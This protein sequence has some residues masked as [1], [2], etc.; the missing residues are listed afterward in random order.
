MKPRAWNI[1]THSSVTSCARNGT[2]LSSP[3]ISDSERGSERG[4]PFGVP[5]VPLVRIVIRGHSSGL[6]G[7]PALGALDQRI[8]RVVAGL[9]RPGAEPPAGR[10]VDPAQ[11]VCVLVVVDE[12]IGPLALGYLP[13]L[14]PR[15]RSVEQHDSCAALRGCE[16][17]LEEAP[18]VA[19]QNR[20]ALAGLQA[21][22]APRVGQRVGALVELLIAELAALV[23]H[24]RPVAVANRPGHDRTREQA[25]ALEAGYQLRDATWRLGSHQPTADA[26][27]GEICLVAGAL[28]KLG[29]ACNQ[30]L[31]VASGA[32]DGLRVQVDYETLLL[33]D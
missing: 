5:V 4:A 19:G 13:D 22:L 1:G 6:G 2:L 24:H 12:Q 20:H 33:R 7:L 21:A 9:V 14:R 8:E 28:G 30:T 15:E 3:P 25:V 18:V 23:D 29:G 10:I 11:G 16:H 27:R 26:Q 32:D 31:G 17:R